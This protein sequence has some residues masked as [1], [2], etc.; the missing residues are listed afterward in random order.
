MDAEY[1]RVWKTQQK[2]VATTS[3]VIRTADLSVGLQL[4]F[5]TSDAPRRE[6]GR[7]EDRG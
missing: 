2:E 4:L 3:G 7:S 1:G 5:G 6:L